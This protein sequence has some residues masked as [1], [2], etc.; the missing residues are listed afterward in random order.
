MFVLGFPIRL[1]GYGV[2]FLL[3]LNALW[4]GVVAKILVDSFHKMAANY[5]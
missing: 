5:E 1:R 3:W 4:R 2:R